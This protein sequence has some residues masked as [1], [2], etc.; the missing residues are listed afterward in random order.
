MNKMKGQ[1]IRKRRRMDIGWA[2]RAVYHGG[3]V[4]HAL[5]CVYMYMTLELFLTDC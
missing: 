3:L 1:L 2:T 4:S 5:L